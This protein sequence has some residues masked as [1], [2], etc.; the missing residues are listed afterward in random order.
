MYVQPCNSEGEAFVG[1]QHNLQSAVVALGEDTPVNGT[2]HTQLHRQL[3]HKSE[4]MHD[5]ALQ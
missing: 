4:W 2:A 3:H 5:D 1:G